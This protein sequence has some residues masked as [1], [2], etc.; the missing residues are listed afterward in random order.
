MITKSITTPLVA[1]FIALPVAAGATAPTDARADILATYNFEPS[2]LPYEE[3]VKKSS[4]IEAIWKRYDAS[5]DSYHSALRSLLNSKGLPEILYCDGA[6][7]LIAKSQPT[8]DI[9]LFVQS[10]GTCSLAEIEQT[11]YF[12]AVHALAVRGLDTFDLQVRM[13]SKPK[14][15]AFIVA[16]AL[17]LGQDFAFLYPLLVQDEA[18]YVSRLIERARAERDPTATVTLLRALWYAATPEAEAALRSL[19]EQR[20]DKTKSTEAK[21]LLERISTIRSLK[22]DD[23]SIKYL[24]SKFSSLL[25]ASNAEIRAKR[26]QRMHSISDEALYDLEAY[27]ALIYRRGNATGA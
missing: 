13:L 2:K 10:L 14:Y 8:E 25:T 1:L 21:I 19:A 12:F 26:R 6:I 3:Q 4:V 17:E 16:H 27:T 20:S 9:S 15:S 23:K 24:E 7:R 22:P 5:P 18:R 11:P